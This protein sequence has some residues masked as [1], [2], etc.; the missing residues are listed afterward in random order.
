MQSGR[1]LTRCNKYPMKYRFAAERKA[2]RKKAANK[3][4][5]AAGKYF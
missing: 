5:T 2:A 1:G 4:I 3:V